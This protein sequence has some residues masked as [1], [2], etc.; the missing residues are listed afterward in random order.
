MSNKILLVFH[1][2][3]TDDHYLDGFKQHTFI[4]SQ[5]MWVRSLG[6]AWLGPLPRV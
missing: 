3:S 5:F 6:L 4:V 2:H 1:N